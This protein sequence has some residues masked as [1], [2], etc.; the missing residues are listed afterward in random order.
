MKVEISVEDI[1]MPII[2][3]RHRGEYI[4][5]RKSSRAMFQKLFEFGFEED[6]IKE[7]ISKA[8]IIYDDNPYITSQK[9][10]RTSVGISLSNDK[11]SQLDDV[12]TRRNIEGKFV[13]F[14]FSLLQSEYAKAWEYIYSD[15]LKDCSCTLRDA[16]PFE[17]YIEDPKLSKTTKTKVDFY[18]PIE[19]ER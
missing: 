6:I 4:K 5:F 19:S 7:G 17:M 18:I 2:Y 13:V 16:A 10:L 8:M 9:E 1:K 12:T 14:H 3:M 15:W 11:K